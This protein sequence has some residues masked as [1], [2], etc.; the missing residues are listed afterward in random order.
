MCL[1]LF[2]KIYCYPW[3]GDR[4]VQ[5]KSNGDG[6]ETERGGANINDKMITFSESL[7]KMS[8]KGEADK[9]P[10]PLCAPMIPDNPDPI[11]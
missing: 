9:P 1:C 11:R 2:A 7:N 4:G 8:K 5:R 10:P 3:Q 6:S